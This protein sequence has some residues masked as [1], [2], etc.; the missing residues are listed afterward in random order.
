MFEQ[1]YLMRLLLQFFAAIN[2]AAQ[3]EQEAEDPQDAADI[4]EQA[5]G[6]ATDMDGAA[7]LSL[8]PDSIAQVMQVSGIDPNVTQFVARSMLLES[9]YLTEA[10]HDKLASVRSAQARAIAGAYGFSLP[11]DPSDFDSIIEGLEEA[12]MRGGFDKEPAGYGGLDKEST[13]H[14]SFPVDDPLAD[15]LAEAGL[16]D[17]F[18]DENF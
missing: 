17:I 5:I 13:D 7:L 9:V 14:D 15:L 12:A 4:L 16:S 10:G 3:R 6:Q 8:S 2:R 11:D 1:D 18:D